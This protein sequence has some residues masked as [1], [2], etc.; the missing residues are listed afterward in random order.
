[1]KCERITKFCSVRNHL[2]LISQIILALFTLGS[3]S[4]VTC[5]RTGS[6]GRV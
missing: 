3:I 4:G 5:V 6:T 2:F 1:M